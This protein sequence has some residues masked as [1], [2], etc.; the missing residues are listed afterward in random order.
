MLENPRVPMLESIGAC[1]PGQFIRL[2]RVPEQQVSPAHRPE[3]GRVPDVIQ[4]PLNTDQI[5][6]GSWQICHC[7]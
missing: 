5:D 4:V 7:E 2:G 1:D 3:L 6:P